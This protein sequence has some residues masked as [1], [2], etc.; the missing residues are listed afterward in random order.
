MECIL[1]EGARWVPLTCR[2]K[3]IAKCVI[4]KLCT[5]QLI[6]N[7]KLCVPHKSIHDLLA[8]VFDL[9]ELNVTFALAGVVAIFHYI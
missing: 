2:H 3:C 7:K 5:R 4:L 9:E 6:T 1:S 8:I